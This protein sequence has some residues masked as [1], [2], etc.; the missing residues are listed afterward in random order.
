MRPNDHHIGP[1]RQAE[2]V[3]TSVAAAMASDDHQKSL[4]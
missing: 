2:I 3:S 1:T 4:R